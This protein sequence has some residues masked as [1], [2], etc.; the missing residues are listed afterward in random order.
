MWLLMAG[1]A[2]MIVIVL[3]GLVGSGAAA[4]FA[5]QPELGRVPYIAALCLA[6]LCSIPASMAADW[7]AV[8]TNVAGHVEPSDPQFWLIVL[9]GSG[10]AMSPAIV[11]FSVLAV[12]VLVSAIGFRRMVPRVA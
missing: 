7:M 11:G 12:I 2:P 9:E 4:R 3:F 5:W 10:E 1:G 6:V 8:A